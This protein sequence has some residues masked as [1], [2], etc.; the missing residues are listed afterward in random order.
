MAE[1]TYLADPNDL[2]TLT[3]ASADNPK[4]LLALRRSTDRFVGGIGWDPQLKEHD[5]ITL[6]GNGTQTLLLPALHI[7]EIDK[8]TANGTDVDDWQADR[9]A[10]ILRREARW[11]DGL[12]NVTVTCTHGWG[13]T[14][15]DI[16]DAVLEQAEIQYRALAGIQTY[17]LG[18]KSIGF[19]ASATVGVTQKWTETVQRYSLGGRV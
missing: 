3:G 9:D 13:T 15:G 5:N 7:T 17:S 16:A 6:N 18:S 4:L 1:T 10:G 8:V 19:G 11:P 14:P 12:G 2:K